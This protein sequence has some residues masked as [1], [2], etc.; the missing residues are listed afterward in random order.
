MSIKRSKAVDNTLSRGAK[1][2]GHGITAII[3]IPAD[4]I[5]KGANMIAPKP[6]SNKVKEEEKSFVGVSKILTEPKTLSRGVLGL[7]KGI[8]KGVTGVVTDPY[9][10]AQSNGFKG[11][12]Q[13]V[14]SGVVGVVARPV[15]GVSDFLESVDHTI[16]GKNRTLPPNYFSAPLIK[17]VQLSKQGDIPNIMFECMT[18]L[19]MRGIDKEGIFRKSGNHIKI[20]ETKELLMAGKKVCF[21]D[22]DIWV[23]A[24]IL[25]LWLRELPR[26]LIPS[27]LYPKLVALGNTLPKLTQE[28]VM[29]WN[30]NVRKIIRTIK[31]P[32]IDCLRVLILFLNKFAKTS[33]LNKMTADNLATVIAPNILYRKVDESTVQTMEAVMQTSEEMGY[34]KQVVKVLITEVEF[35]FFSDD[36]VETVSELK[37]E[38]TTTENV[39]AENSKLLVLSSIDKNNSPSVIVTDAK[40]APPDREAEL[41]TEQ[42]NHDNGLSTTATI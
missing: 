8:V 11:F 37:N 16:D 36:I 13:G 38:E 7:G 2:V 3:K 25:K 23:I 28:E 30:I 1:A 39:G 17:Q 22:L 35:F 29:D 26:P 33:E 14:G 42:K 12:V 15:K 4:G 40:T 32:E 41:K 24:S 5:V 19:Q 31:A 21:F 18:Q 20:Q 27:W 6:Q 10:G 9:K 34:A